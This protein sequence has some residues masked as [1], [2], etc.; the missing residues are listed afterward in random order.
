[1]VTFSSLVA[2]LLGVACSLVTPYPAPAKLEF[3]R[4]GVPDF[5]IGNNG[6]LYRRQDYVQDD[7]TGGIVDFSHNGSY[8]SV[9]WNTGHPFIVGIG[10]SHGSTM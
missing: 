2:A 7:T 3:T 8:F 5:S 6:D 4:R 10:W 1:M 9:T